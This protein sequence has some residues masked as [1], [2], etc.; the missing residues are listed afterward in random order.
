MEMRCIFTCLIF[1][2]SW[3]VVFEKSFFWYSPFHILATFTGNSVKTETCMPLISMIK[4]CRAENDIGKKISCMPRLVGETKGGALTD[5][6]K[7]ND[8]YVLLRVIWN[9]ALNSESQSICQTLSALEVACV[10][11]DSN[12]LLPTYSDW[13]FLLHCLGM[14]INVAFL[15]LTMLNL[16]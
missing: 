4:F 13:F 10:N 1:I 15:S 9:C 11:T 12:F 16:K 14:Y 7:V 5:P 8:N 6:Q 3:T 2:K